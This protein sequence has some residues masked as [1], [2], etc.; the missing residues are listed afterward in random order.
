M[1]MTVHSEQID[2]SLLARIDAPIVWLR[3]TC[4]LGAKRENIEHQGYASCYRTVPETHDLLARHFTVSS[5]DRVYP[6]ELESAFGTKQFYFEARRR[7]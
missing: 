6:D 1:V 3:S 4:T 5:V 7:S 2:S